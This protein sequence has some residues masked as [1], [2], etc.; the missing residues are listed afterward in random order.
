MQF[1]T[2][3]RLVYCTALFPLVEFMSL[4]YIVYFFLCFTARLD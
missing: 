2:F 4:Q 3:D 1:V